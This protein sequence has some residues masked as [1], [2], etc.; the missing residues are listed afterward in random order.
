MTGK[1]L[2]ATAES[3]AGVLRAAVPRWLNEPPN[4]ARILAFAPARDRH[5]G[6]GALYVLLKRLR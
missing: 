2:R 6:A 3:P 4:R 1:G 5:G